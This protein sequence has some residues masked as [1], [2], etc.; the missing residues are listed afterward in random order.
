M[1][2]IACRMHAVT[3]PRDLKASDGRRGAM[4]AQGIE[5]LRDEPASARDPLAALDRLITPDRVSAY[6]LMLIGGYALGA[7]VWIALLK[8][9]VDPL[10]KPLGGDFIIFYA[11]SKLGL[12]GHALSAFKP[13][14]LLAAERS[15]AP[16][17]RGLFLWCYPPPFQ[18][19]T[20]PL[21]LIP[22]QAALAAWTAGGLA[23]Y[24]AM[25]RGLSRAPGAL[26]LALAFPAVFV[27]AMQ[28]QNGFLVAGLLG[29]GLLLVDRRPWLAGAL[30]G[31]LVFKPQFGV[32]LPLVLIAG[33]RWR[34][35]AATAMSAA[36]LIAV[37]TA[38]FGVEAWRDFLAF[39]PQVSANLADGALP[40]Y[41]VPSVFAA[42]R[43]VDAPAPAALAANLALAAP[44]VV[45]ACTAWRR[46]GPLPLKAGLAVLATLLASPYAFDYDLVL[47]AI[48][49]GALAEHIRTD[50]APTGTRALIALGFLTPIA[51][52]PIARF[53]HLQLTPLVL[54]LLI[55]A[56]WRALK[57]ERL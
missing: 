14:A 55:A 44:V 37:S 36:L 34:T 43:L 56:T 39:L 49:L 6:A 22:Y 3:Q 8:G 12:T 16:A 54:L 26:L 7:A 30:L 51:A 42:L 28:G 38:M 31:F 41:K 33:G 57:S 17:S 50:G 45:L 27:T 1:R 13:A 29:G 32:L 23:A 11:A 48:P 9:G 35:I 40:L 15:V 4:T 5:H 2:S 21:A 19:L 53:A 52:T 47:L 18:L 25:T 24:F 20:L 10:G 46:P